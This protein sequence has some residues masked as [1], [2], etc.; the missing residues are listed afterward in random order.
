[1][2]EHTCIDADV[3]R[4]A[5]VDALSKNGSTPLLVASREG[6][7]RVCKALLKHGADADDGGDKGWTPLSVAAGEGHVEVCEI[8]LKYNANVSGPSLLELFKGFWLLSQG[9][10]GVFYGVLTWSR[11]LNGP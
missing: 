4:E 7:T 9:P 6:H 1:M 2:Y 5:N 8:L 11:L 10:R 3:T